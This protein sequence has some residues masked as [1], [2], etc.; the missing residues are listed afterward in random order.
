MPRTG[1]AM[2][3][4]EKK[5]GADGRLLVRWSGTEPKLRIMVE[6]PDP[7]RIE[8]MAQQIADTAAAELAS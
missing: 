6:G 5:L 3:A 8:E 7:E 1:K 4:V 2:K